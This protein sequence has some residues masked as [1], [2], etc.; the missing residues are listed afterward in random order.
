MATLPCPSCYHQ[1]PCDLLNGCL[2]PGTILCSHDASAAATV[3][4]AGIGFPGT[5]INNAC[6]AAACAVP[7]VGPCCAAGADPPT[8]ARFKGWEYRS[9]QLSA[10]SV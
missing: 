6:L 3:I 10:M 1:I 7:G 8:P 9:P 5:D 2:V 4:C